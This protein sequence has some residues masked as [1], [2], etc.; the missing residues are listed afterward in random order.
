M[1]NFKAVRLADLADV[2]TITKGFPTQ[3]AV[4]EGDVRVMSIAALR[5]QTP[6]KLYADR[7]AISEAGLRTAQAGD[8]LVAVE[9]GTVGETMIVAAG[10]DEFVPSQQVATIRISDTLFPIS[11]TLF[12]DLVLALD[13]YYLGAWLSTEQ[14]REQIR[15]LAR[16][17][18]VQRIPVSDLASLTVMI[19]PLEDQ[20]AIGRRFKAFENAIRKHQAV[21]AHL[22]DLCDLD[23]VV[24]FADAEERSAGGA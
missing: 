11:D 7:D 10:I 16:G 2:L 1:T 21:T 8:V 6:P 4:P 3:H 5:N 22:Q 13:P 23:L 9:G 18:A 12:P 24:T 17:T 15:R 20:L 19:P 14:A